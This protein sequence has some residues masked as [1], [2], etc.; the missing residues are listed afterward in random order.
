MKMNKVFNIEDYFAFILLNFGILMIFLIPPMASPD[1]NTHFYNAYALSEFDIFPEVMN[2]EIGRIQPK[3]IV[4]FVEYYN[5]KFAGKLNEKYT[6]E[7]MYMD[8]WVTV[9]MEERV[10]HSYWNADAHIG[11]YIFAALGMLFFKIIAKI[12]CIA[13]ITPYNLLIVGRIFNLLFYTITIYFSIKI[14]PYLKK[15]MFLFAVMPMSSFLAVSLSYDAILIPISFLLCSYTMR[16]IRDNRQITKKDV[17]VIG[18]ITA[19]LCM[20]KQAYIGLLLI[21]FAISI[22]LFKSKKQYV[23]VITFILLIGIIAFC[24]YA[25]GLS[26]RTKN[27]TGIWDQIQQQQTEIILKEPLLFLKTI[28]NSFFRY[29]HFYFVSFLGNLGQLDTNFPQII[30]ISYSI[31]T[32]VTGIFEAGEIEETSI[33]KNMKFLVLM[34][35]LI[36]TYAIFA[37]TYIIWTGMMQGIGTDFV[38]GVQG[39]YFIPLSIYIVLLFA[40]HRLKK[41]NFYSFINYF[42]QRI[43][44]WLGCI[45]SIF[46]LLI[47]LLR[48]WI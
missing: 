36:T 31:L 14:T 20:I 32:V 28:F 8:G 19:F 2:H 23:K 16:L 12:F 40:N 35:L 17:L 9:D 33:V 29:G 6:F 34:G 11:G 13:I 26:I 46:L 5:T 10:F 25:L 7:S 43:I 4:N 41:L 24:S 45:I 38:D 15:T 22:N 37:G 27:F 3:E 39:R 30:L 47:L 44:V 42:L 48:F 18:V 1:E 21:L